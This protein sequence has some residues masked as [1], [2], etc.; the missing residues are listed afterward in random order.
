MGNYV[1]FVEPVYT[2]QICHYPPLLEECNAL[3]A[4]EASMWHTKRNTKLLVRP[5]LK[6]ERSRNRMALYQNHNPLS[7]LHMSRYCEVEDRIDVK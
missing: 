1:W 5:R 7:R 3:L 6:K 2:P 4:S